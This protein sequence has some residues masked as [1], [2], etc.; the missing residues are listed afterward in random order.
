MPDRIRLTTHAKIPWTVSQVLK[1]AY[2]SGLLILAYRE[3][4]QSTGRLIRA[5]WRLIS[6]FIKCLVPPQKLGQYIVRSNLVFYIIE[7][8][9]LR[10]VLKTPCD[11][12]YLMP[13]VLE[14]RL[15]GNI[16]ADLTGG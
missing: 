5:L 9:L 11:F 16:I 10:M 15:K 3:K 8:P 12:Y 13:S 14:V 6:L 7:N 1:L 2:F 4:S